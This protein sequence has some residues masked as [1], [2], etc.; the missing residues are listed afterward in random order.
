M[1]IQISED[2]EVTPAYQEELCRCIGLPE[3]VPLYSALDQ[4][5]GDI[6]EIKPE[7]QTKINLLLDLIASHKPNSLIEAQMVAQLLVCHKLSMRMLNKVSKES[8]PEISEKYLNM[9]MKLSRNFNKGLETLSKFRRDG[10]QRIS[11]EHVSVEKDGQ[12]V[13]GNLDRE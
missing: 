11:I 12:A 8:F 2:L 10:K 9:A 4:L 13:I 5:M 7:N 1:N 6:I 3:T